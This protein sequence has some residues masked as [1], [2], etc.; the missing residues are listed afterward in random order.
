MEGSNAIW[1]FLTTF[2][3]LHKPVQDSSLFVPAVL[4]RYLTPHHQPLLLIIPDF[5]PN[6]YLA[7]LLTLCAHRIDFDSPMNILI[8]SLPCFSKLILSIPSTVFSMTS[9]SGLSC[10][11]Q[12]ASLPLELCI[13]WQPIKGAILQYC[14]LLRISGEKSCG[15]SSHSVNSKHPLSLNHCKYSICLDQLSGNG[16]CHITILCGLMHSLNLKGLS[17]ILQ[18]IPVLSSL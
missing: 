4:D 14:S 13:A 12:Y 5:L 11:R 9:I 16:L 2:D 7:H 18:S 15:W 8:E 17:C 6:I 10:F 3:I 1:R